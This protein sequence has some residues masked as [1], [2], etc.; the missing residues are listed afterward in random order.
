MGNVRLR[1][2][3]ESRREVPVGAVGE[4]Y[5]GGGGVARGYL[6]R[7]GLT[8]E[9]FVELEGG[10]YYRSGDLG[11]WLGTGVVGF[12][13]RADEQVKVRGYR[14][15]LGEVEA[16]VTS[17]AGVRQCVV[18][19]RPDASGER[20]LVAYYVAAEGGEEVSAARLR[21]HVGGLLPDYM[22]PSAY[23][24][25]DEMPLTALSKVD[26]R[27][28]PEPDAEA[29]REGE[30]VAPRTEVEEVLASIWGELLGVGR[31]GVGDNFFELGGHSLLATQLA[32]RVREAFGAEVALREVFEHPTLGGLALAVE[33]AARR[34]AGVSAPPIMAAGRD[35]ALPLSFAQQRLWFIDQFEPNSSIYN[36]P[37]AVRLSG[38]LNVDA[39]RETLS[40]IVRRHE[41]LRTTFVSVD[42]RP[43]QVIHP[44]RPLNLPLVDLGALPAET[45]RAESERL[46]EE[47]ARRPFDL[48]AGPLLRVMLLR[49][50]A[51]EHVVLFT[52]HHVVSD[53]WSMG[54]FIKEVVALYGAYVE[55]R[56]SPLPELEV[57]YA[58]YAVWQRGWLDGAVLD[59]QVS[60]WRGQLE[61]AP[62]VLEL[63]TDRPR[64]AMQRHRG[65]RHPFALSAETSAGLRELSR[66]EGA[67]LFMVLLAGWQLLL[68]R[69]S[70][71]E[72]VVVGTPIA[73]RNRAEVEPL[74]GFFVNTLALRARVAPG[75]SFRELLAQVRE[76][77][78][79]AYAHQD[80]PFEKLVEELQ[81]ERSLSHTPLFQVTFSFQ[82]MPSE[83]LVLPSL[84]LSPM[85]PEA[86]SVKF[87]LSLF[88]TEDG[89]VLRMMIAYNAGL[90]EA[91]SI[92]RMA[93]HFERLLSEVV[94]DATQQLSSI[95]LLSE[96]ERER[97]LVEWNDT[98]AEYPRQ[99]CIHELF[100][101]W[102]ERT[103][104]AVAVV[105]ESERLTYSELS[106]RSSLLARRL[107]SLGVGA[108]VPVALCLGRSEELVVAML[109][110]LK[111][112]GAYVPLDP[113]YPLSRLSLML[114]DCGAPVLVTQTRW[115][116]SL[117]AYQGQV[118][119]L[120]EEGEGEWEAD[121][122][123]AP[124]R[125]TA[126]SLAYVIYTSGSTGTPKGVCVTHRGVSRL[127]RGADYVDLGAG[128]VLLQYAPATFDAATFE[129]W[130]ALL[131]GGRL[132]VMGEGAAGLEELGARV[133]AEGVTTLWLTTG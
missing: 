8:A 105:G 58:D 94:R 123:P 49:E 24:R 128:E 5:I 110:V 26:R 100:E 41:A 130:G 126:D 29:E 81:P 119:C 15:E 2:L 124:A 97:L 113:N 55:G 91:E 87:D 79:G 63:P 43:V 20:R 54:V 39:L 4:I 78:L 83:P 50:G 106:R 75:E 37:A 107:T 99:S 104:E 131:N 47:E 46:A 125:A 129:V 67:S 88:A 56:P 109:G 122:A 31:V 120:D 28:L 10:R 96:S 127:V 69:Y 11:R 68:S 36:S 74:I 92:G 116:D 40:E 66:R 102:A 118:L 1:L 14:I 35:E 42:G 76:T 32:S 65:G 121:D 16:A 17:H 51:E 22:V 18:A 3:D 101:E 114:E 57:Q 117:P 133:R 112:G 82:N 62:S 89:D 61:G 95:R 108:E 6:N 38:S 44:P 60:Y 45:R 19:A 9:R 52:T 115:L 90:F 84:T 111:A 33:G 80:L 59:E 13:G 64:G 73:N 132:A 48:E 72:D 25:L 7:P 23:V 71:Q 30:Y 27:A 103:P 21:E 77:C 34:G 12:V 93:E 85:L 70:G 53:G 86:E 98:A